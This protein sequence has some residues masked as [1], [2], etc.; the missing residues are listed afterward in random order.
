M[1]ND[2]ILKDG[3]KAL[4]ALAVIANRYHPDIQDNYEL[5][6]DFFIALQLVEQID[7]VVI[8]ISAP[9]EGRSAIKVF[10]DVLNRMKKAG[11]GDEK[12]KWNNDYSRELDTL[13]ILQGKDISF[14]DTN[15]RDSLRVRHKIQIS[16]EEMIKFSN[17][18]TSLDPTYPSRCEIISGSPDVCKDSKEYYEAYLKFKA[19]GASVSRKDGQ[20]AGY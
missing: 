18:L 15:I 17:Y 7:N 4:P 14:S 13:K 16:D 5:A 3:V 11:F 19:E 1:I 10:E 2:Y 6:V 9:A 12:N 20:A 8:R